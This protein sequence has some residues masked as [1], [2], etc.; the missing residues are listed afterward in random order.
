[1]HAERIGVDLDLGEFVVVVLEPEKEA[2]LERETF[3]GGAD[4]GPEE[5]NPADTTLAR[6]RGYRICVTYNM[7]VR[8]TRLMR[9]MGIM[10]C[11]PSAIRGT[12][13]SASF[14]SD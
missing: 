13:L 3:G 2:V 14:F 12:L 5:E 4:R 10:L 9:D 6:I 7:G 11:P 1:L 8:K